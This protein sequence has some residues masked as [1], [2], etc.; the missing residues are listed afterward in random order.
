MSFIKKIL[1]KSQSNNVDIEE[2]L[3]TI[4]TTEESTEDADAFVKPIYL[5]PDTDLKTVAKEL[6]NGNFILLNV[7]E[8]MKRN[9]LRLKEQVNKLKRFS[10]EIDG[11]IARISEEKLLLTPARIKILK[12]K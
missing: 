3:N 4:D 5:K 10:E 8:L 9:P 7:E 11:D 12:R 1:T 6:K 2:F